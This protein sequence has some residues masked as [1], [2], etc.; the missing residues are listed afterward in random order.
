MFV[1]NENTYLG[2]SQGWLFH[3]DICTI[4]L[5]ALRGELGSSPGRFHPA[6]LLVTKSYSHKLANICYYSVLRIDYFM[7]VDLPYL[8]RLG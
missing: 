7:Y 6:I 4:G 2:L 5:T 1:V 3:S 8:A